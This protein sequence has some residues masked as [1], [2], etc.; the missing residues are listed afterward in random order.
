MKVSAKGFEPL[1]NGLK[2]RY[3]DIAFP[4]Q[5]TMLFAL[6]S[7]TKRAPSPLDTILRLSQRVF[8]AIVP[9]LMGNSALTLLRR[10]KFS[11]ILSL[12]LKTYNFSSTLSLIF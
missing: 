6:V 12:F 1:T 2:E 9:D 5:G 4:V 11:L 8:E 10:S 7:W 3:C